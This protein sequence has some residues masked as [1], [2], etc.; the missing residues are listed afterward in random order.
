MDSIQDDM[1]FGD[2]LLEEVVSSD[3]WLASPV[4]G[5]KLGGPNGRRFEI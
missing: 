1:D 2:S 5:E 4:P 3:P